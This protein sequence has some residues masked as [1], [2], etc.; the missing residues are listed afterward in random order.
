[1]KTPSVLVALALLAFVKDAWCRRH[2]HG[3][4]SKYGQKI[5]GGYNNTIDNVPYIVYL[6]IQSPK[7]EYFQCGGSIISDR[8][9][10]TAAHCVQGMVKAII[11]A[12]SSDADSGGTQYTSSTLL[13]H[14][15]YNSKNYDHDA[16]LIR[17][18]RR[19]RLDGKTVKA[20]PLADDGCDV[21]SGT[22]V[23]VSGWGATSENGEVSSDLM[24]VQVQSVS[25]DVCQQQLGYSVTDCQFCAGVPE[26]GKDS[27]Q[28]D[29]GG[30]AVQAA[31][32]RGGTSQRACPSAT[33]AQIGI[34]S[35]GIGCARPGKPGVYTKISCSTVRSWIKLTAGV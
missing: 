34:V 22:N 24:S 33:G 8:Y 13:L 10:L 1:M 6:L 16:A 29:S 4:K 11:R 25:Q 27:C 35:N 18:T 31:S 9:I 26:G 32:S 3:H 2:F 28:G 5:V 20:I 12:G 23:M 15:L 14:P 19:I 21:S 30:P 7:N 17:T